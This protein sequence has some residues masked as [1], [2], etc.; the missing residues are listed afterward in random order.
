VGERA[1]RP[2]PGLAV[3]WDAWGSKRIDEPRVVSPGGEA[4]R[5]L[6]QGLDTY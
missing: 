2:V 4:W 6:L 5:K 3:V 1:C